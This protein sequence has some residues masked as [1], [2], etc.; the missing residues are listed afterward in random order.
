MDVNLMFDELLPQW[1]EMFANRSRWNV[2]EREID[3]DSKIILTG[4]YAFAFCKVFVPF[5]AKHLNTLK[6]SAY[7]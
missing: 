4:L 3:E 1:R 6:C 5:F 7:L 2:A